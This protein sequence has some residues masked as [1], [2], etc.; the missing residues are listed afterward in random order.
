[1]FYFYHL[2]F[3]FSFS[4]LSNKELKTHQNQQL[5]ED[6]LNNVTFSNSFAEDL[7]K[8]FVE[9]NI[10]FSVL[11]NPSF[12]TWYKKYVKV[13]S[14][15]RRTVVSC[16]K[17]FSE[18]Y[19]NKIKLKVNN[20]KIYLIVDESIDKLSRHVLN[21]LVGVLNGKP[22]K[23]MLFN[24]AIVEKCNN[25]TVQQFINNSLNFLYDSNIKY[26]NVK[27]LI[28]DQAEY[29]KRA[30]SNLKLLYTSMR[31][32][33]CLAHA[34]HV[35]CAEIRDE[36]N[37][38]NCLIGCMKIILGGSPERKQLFKSITKIERLPPK[39]NA[40]RWGTWVDAA[41]FYSRNFIK[42]KLFINSL[43]TNKSKTIMEAKKLIL[44]EEL[45]QQLNKVTDFEFLLD[46]IKCLQTENLTVLRQLE[47]LDIVMKNLSGNIQLRFKKSLKKNPDLV[48][49]QEQ[50]RKM[51]L[52]L[53]LDY[54][55]LPF[56]SVSVERSFSLLKNIL[57]ERRQCLSE[58]N[59][60]SLM[61]IN[62]NKFLK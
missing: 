18:F 20:E 45:S 11:D 13:F 49:L 4:H 27:F 21:I 60:K 15:S 52:K 26:E 16:L 28:T 23:P 55:F 19:L 62:F 40:V 22:C 12:K 43:D 3:N 37:L 30:G 41:N 47:I 9:C 44:K 29:M 6:C 51:P 14:P 53:Q 25:E 50:Y 57:T 46:Y 36:F 61:I 10:P 58:E 1:M 24:V 17:Q 5:L 33:T 35:T 48:Y 8:L 32:V 42:I 54:K 59:L 31:H 7:C 39:A 34:L 38:V 2:F 56:T